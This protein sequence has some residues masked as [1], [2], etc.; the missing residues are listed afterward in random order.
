MSTTALTPDGKVVTL[1]AK[2]LRLLEVLKEIGYGRFEVV[3]VD[4][5]PDRVE[6]IRQTVKL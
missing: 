3:M 4:G 2:Q 6:N 5:E 1:S